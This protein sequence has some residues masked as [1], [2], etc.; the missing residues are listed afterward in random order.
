MPTTGGPT[1]LRSGRPY[2]RH[3][4]FADLSPSRWRNGGGSTY[5]LAVEPIGSSMDDFDWRVSIAAVEEPGPFSTFPGVDRILTLIDGASMQLTVDGEHHALQLLSSVHLAGE[6]STSC[7]LP[8]GPT[9]DLNVMTRRGTVSATVELSEI[10][11]PVQIRPAWRLLLVVVTGQVEVGQLSLQPMD[12][13]LSSAAVSTRV[14]GA[15]ILAAVRL[16]H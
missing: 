2:D 6:S 13:V 15:G 5:E 3:W 8:D 14:D 1:G 12:G 4:R 10:T 16:T 11:G 7:E 9:R